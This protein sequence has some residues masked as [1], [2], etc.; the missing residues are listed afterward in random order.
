MSMP[1]AAAAEPRKSRWIPW[2]FILGFLVVVAVN[3]TMIAF[4]VNSFTGLTTSE[5]YT[6]GLRFNDQIRHVEAQERLG[7]HLAARFD[8]SGAQSG[9]VAI[10]LSDRSAAPLVGARITATFARPVEKNRE[11]TVAFQSAGNGRYVG[12]AEFPLP[13]VW[14]VTYRIERDGQSL[15]ARDRIEV[16]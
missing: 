4:A 15:E 9:D 8:K 2:V 13:G 10:Q 11:F 14:D 12:H 3:G 1:S 6:K 5:P 16:Q 7:W